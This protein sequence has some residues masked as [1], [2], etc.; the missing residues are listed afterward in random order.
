MNNK[1]SLTLLMFVLA[2]SLW[3]TSSQAGMNSI[4]QTNPVYTAEYPSPLETPEACGNGEKVVG[5]ILIIDPQGSTLALEVHRLSVIAGEPDQIDT[6]T[7]V[8]TPE[9]HLMRD[10]KSMPLTD[11][12]VFTMGTTIGVMGGVVQNG[13][14][15]ARCIGEDVVRMTP[16]KRFPGKSGALLKYH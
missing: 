7:V 9:T 16:V 4:V 3:L 10:R 5:K 11:L 14:M 13:R 8:V 12:N 2:S 6:I 15:Q 1:L